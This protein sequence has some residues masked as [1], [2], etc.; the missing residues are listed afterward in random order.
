MTKERQDKINEWLKTVESISS[1]T[2][3]L[4]SESDLLTTWD[5][6]YFTIIKYNDGKE[7]VKES[8]PYK[9]SIMLHEIDDHLQ[10][11]GMQLRDLNKNFLTDS[12]CYNGISFIKIEFNR[13]HTDMIK[14]DKHN[15]FT[16]TKERF[17]HLIKERLL[18]EAKLTNNI[19][20]AREIKLRNLLIE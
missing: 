15:W 18:E 2:K 20:L 9:P 17:Q 6:Q 7:E 5:S 19:T 13:C 11:W 1:N 12:L 3:S 4:Y 14:F 10:S 16:Y 8:K